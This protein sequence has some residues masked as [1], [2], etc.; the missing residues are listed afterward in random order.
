[1]AK[2]RLAYK[3]G[4]SRVLLEGHVDIHHSCTID[5]ALKRV[6]AVMKKAKMKLEKPLVGPASHLDLQFHNLC[7][8]RKQR[9]RVER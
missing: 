3:V 5:S 1:M 6:H 7:H 8:A 9:K 4:Q 2:G